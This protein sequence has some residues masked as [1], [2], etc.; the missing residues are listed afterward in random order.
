MTSYKLTVV[1]SRAKRL[2]I[3][4]RCRVVVLWSFSVVFF[5]QYR[6]YFELFILTWWIKVIGTR[7]TGSIGWFSRLSVSLWRFSIAGRLCNVCGV[8]WI[9]V[10]VAR[11][12][13]FHRLGSSHHGNATRQPLKG[14]LSFGIVWRS[15]LDCI[16]DD[17]YCYKFR[18]WAQL[19]Q[20]GAL[21]FSVAG[22]WTSV[23]TSKSL[24]SFCMCSNRQQRVLT[25]PWANSCFPAL[26]RKNVWKRQT[27]SYQSRIRRTGSNNAF[28][29]N[30]ATAL[31]EQALFGAS[32]DCINLWLFDYTP[33]NV[34]Q[35]HGLGWWTPGLSNVLAY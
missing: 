29:I 25:C 10:P 33:F 7:K 3:L 9:Q 11:F 32:R 23:L 20:D 14:W 16:F 8:V 5:L 15:C 12:V 22:T 28:A 21:F 17:S 34:V 1:R 18:V 35:L 2:C 13:P 24:S 27:S 19:V 30:S 4:S 31:T 6:A 26:S